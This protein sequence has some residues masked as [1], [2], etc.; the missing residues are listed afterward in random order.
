V[1]INVLGPIEVHDGGRTIVL[2]GQRQR[3]LLAALTLEQGK[4]V[5]VD[6]LVD[7]LWDA[8]PPATARAKIHAH[9]SALR[10][11]L[12]Y[13]ARTGAGP[14]LT[15]PPGYALDLRGITLDLVEFGSLT[16][17]GRES[18]VTQAWAGASGL[19]AQALA[20][21]RGQAYADV[22]SRLI[23]SAAAALEEIRLL[24]VE[25]KAEADL[26]L[27]QCQT[28]VAELSRE[29]VKNPF[30]E[31]LRLHLMV[32]LYRLGSR[33]D[34]LAVYREGRRAMIEELGLEPGQQLRQLHQSILADLPACQPG[35]RPRPPAAGEPGQRIISNGS[36]H[37]PSL[38]KPAQ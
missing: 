24:A 26:A 9:V 21:W 1:Q 7:I 10:H 3:A 29:L 25:S 20:L 18:A 23:S 8:N 16:A 27:G 13:S 32:A 2:T 30:R 17:R 11:A 5:P 36:P 34:A 14:L 22:T 37:L 33:A 4:V 15:R 35:A 38:A 31:R 6:R 28:V 12:G 19:F